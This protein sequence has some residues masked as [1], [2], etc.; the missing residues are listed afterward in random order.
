MRTKIILFAYYTTALLVCLFVALAHPEAV[1][2][3]WSDTL[4]VLLAL[5]CLYLMIS[6]S[7]PLRQSI[8][9]HARGSYKYQKGDG[10]VF[11]EWGDEPGMRK[12]WRHEDRVYYANH[13]APFVF[14]LSAL[15]LPPFLPIILF[16]DEMPTLTVSMLLFAAVATAFS[17]RYYKDKSKLMRQQKEERERALKEHEE[18]ERKKHW[19]Y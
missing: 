13:T 6:H 2:V 4:A 1:L 3:T 19:K 12:D 5:F 18:Q 14:W 17:I 8:I 9:D 16:L 7:P 15:T 10:M 11:V